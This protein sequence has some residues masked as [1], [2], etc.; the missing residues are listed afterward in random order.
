MMTGEFS[1]FWHFDLA[2]QI[3]G[4]KKRGTKEIMWAEQRASERERQWRSVVLQIR[5]KKTKAGN[6]DKVGALVKDHFVIWFLDRL[7]N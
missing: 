3:Y 2:F 5:P 7:K 1:G 6:Q 4:P